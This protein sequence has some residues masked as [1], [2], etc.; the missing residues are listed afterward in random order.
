MNLVQADD[1]LREQVIE[2]KNKRIKNLENKINDVTFNIKLM[3]DRLNQ[4]KKRQKMLSHSKNDKPNKTQK[5]DDVQIQ[6]SSQEMLEQIDEDSTEKSRTQLLNLVEDISHALGIHDYDSNL[7]GV[8]MKIEH[9]L[10]HFIEARNHLAYMETFVKPSQ[11][12]EVDIFKF[13]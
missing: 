1:L 2:K 7:V 4:A 11:K 8:L 3:Q 6:F 5:H 10:I 9:Q 12:Q 13:E